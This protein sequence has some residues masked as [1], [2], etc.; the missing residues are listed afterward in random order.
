MINSPLQE[1]LRRL[2][3]GQVYTLDELADVLD[4]DGSLLQQ[5]FLDL[6]RAGCIRSQRPT[7]ERSCPG[8]SAHDCSGLGHRG[9]LWI[10][11][12]KGRHL[13]GI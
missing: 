6:E 12:A 13:A 11:T 3:L 2:S 7:C 9:R 5:M 4:V 10:L 1:L 8:C